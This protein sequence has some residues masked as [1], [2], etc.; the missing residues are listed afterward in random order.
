MYALCSNTRPHTAVSS[1]FRPAGREAHVRDPQ[2][3][4]AALDEI[5]AAGGSVNL[6]MFHGGTTHGFNNGANCREGLYQPTIGSYDYDAPLDEAGD[7]TPKYHAFRQVIAK[8]APV[9]DAPVPGPAPKRAYGKVELPESA[10]LLG[11]PGRR[12]PSPSIPRRPSRWN[13]STRATASSSTARG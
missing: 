10:S 5:L 1:L 6:Y 2:D 3:A 11:S 4:A 13:I 9:P 8:Y 12:S 7:P